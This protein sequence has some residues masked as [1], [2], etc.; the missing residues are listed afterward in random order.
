MQNAIITGI[1]LVIV[2][3]AVF[4]ARKHFKGGGCCGSGS[5]TIRDKKVLTAP[6]IGEMVLTI[7]G[8]HCENCAI[9]IENAL[10]RLDGV[11]CK[12]NPK[13]KIATVLY[14]AEPS[15]TQLTGIVEQ[16]GYQVTA[17]R[18]SAKTD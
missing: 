14:S 3:F 10:N 6:K 13:K 8:M 15:R 2:G 12:A 1:L 9:R 11:L 18:E 7:E 17:V 5:R 16:L 4:R